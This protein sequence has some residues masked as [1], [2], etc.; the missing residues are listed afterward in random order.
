MID[1]AYIAGWNCLQLLNETMAGNS[2]LIIFTD[3]SG[4]FILVA[5]CYGI[6]K[7]DLSELAEKARLIAFVDIGYTTLQASIVAFNKV[8]S[9][10]STCLD[11]QRFN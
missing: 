11:D 7:G 8:K 5:L 2:R 10:V 3:F 4:L 1:A 9:K 6:N